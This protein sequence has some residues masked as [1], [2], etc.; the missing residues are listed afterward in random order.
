M[1]IDAANPATEEAA[2]YGMGEQGDTISAADLFAPEAND[3][4][5]QSAKQNQTDAPARKKQPT[6]R[7]FTSDDMSRAV[8]NR[9]KQER[10]GAAYKLGRELLDEYMR[11]NNV[12]EAD[13]L[14]RIREERISSKAAEYKADPE[15]GFRELMQQ[16]EQRIE[17]EE[18][19]QTSE[20]KAQILYNSIVADINSGKVPS[21]FNL[22]A[23]LSDRENAKQFLELYEAFGMEKACAYT[24]RMSAPVQTRTEQ[25]RALPKP[26]S[27]NNAYNPQPIDYMGMS[28]KD[29]AELEQKMKKA[30]ANGKRVI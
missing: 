7:T 15:K 19:T 1:T 5:E 13:A 25:N 22:E 4:D 14:A 23:H 27:T 17:P 18:E 29:F 12:S 30:R 8:Q 3:A 6:E 2:A 20:A 10:R 24:M 21:G 26:I 16:R 28:S 11:A 9:L